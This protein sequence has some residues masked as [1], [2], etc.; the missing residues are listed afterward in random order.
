MQYLCDTNVVSE[1]MRR[2]PNSHVVSWLESQ[3]R[4]GLSVVSVEEIHCGLAYKDAL[5]QLGWFE[6]FCEERCVVLPV[7]EE[8]AT[9]AGTL[10]GQFRKSGTARTQADM[11][12]A[13]TAARHG[14]I[15]ATRNVSDF[16]HCGVPLLNPFPA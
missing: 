1:I 10:R 13:A 14:L 6:R 11:L 2:A 3:D 4:I 8:I 12:I 9:R 15:L 7:S 16:D 5:R